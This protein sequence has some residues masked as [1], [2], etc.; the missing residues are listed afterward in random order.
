MGSSGSSTSQSKTNSNGIVAIALIVFR[1]FAGGLQVRLHVIMV[2]LV[3]KTSNNIGGI[4]MKIQPVKSNTYDTVNVVNIVRYIT[5]YSDWIQKTVTENPDKLLQ[6]SRTSLKV[7]AAE[8]ETVKKR[9][10][11]LVNNHY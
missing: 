11:Y 10:D 6:K 1:E 3:R 7:V 2:L 9:L 5:E 8:L 4:K